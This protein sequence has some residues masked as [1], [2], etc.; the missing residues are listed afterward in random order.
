MSLHGNQWVKFQ[1]TGGIFA[2]NTKPIL[3]CLP[4]K[5][6]NFNFSYHMNEPFLIEMSIELKR[7]A[8]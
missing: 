5:A 6:G 2:T 4:S 3:Q 1:V 8:T 7:R